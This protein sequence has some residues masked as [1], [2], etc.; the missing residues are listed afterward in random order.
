MKESRGAADPRPV[1]ALLKRKLFDVRLFSD[2]KRTSQEPL[3]RGE[4]LYDFYNECGRNGY[5][6]FRSILNLWLSEIESDEHRMELIS[7]AK[8]G[9]DTAFKGVLCELLTHA[10][11]I[12]LGY[13]IAVHPDVQASKKRPD[14]GLVDESGDII[15][16]IEVTTINRADEEEGQSNREAAIYNAI[17]N[18]AL[19][20]GCLLG[21]SLIKAGLDSPPLRPLVTSIERWAGENEKKARTEEVVRRFN[22]GG[23]TFEIELFSGGSAQAGAPAI[24]VASMQGGR[25]A[26]AED[27]R[28]ALERKSRRYGNLNVPY[29]IVVAD[30]KNQILRENA[31]R[32]AIVEAVY[33]DDLVSVATGGEPRRVHD[34]NGFWFRGDGC[35]NKH[36]SAILLM[37]DAG[38]WKLREERWQPLLAVNL[39]ANFSIPDSIKELTRIDAEQA[40]WVRRE[41]KLVADVL[42]LPV[43]WPPTE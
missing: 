7:R 22:A 35:H 6:E 28:T 31:V 40:K 33:G 24:G 19:P 4:R 18:S 12:R 16:Y 41:G 8:N 36:V 10:L 23:W 30:A 20:A 3:Q 27:V 21:Y 9:G 29:V 2:G 37:P 43:P 14:F 32:D 25:I 15:C 39:S 42:S 5:D 1:N 26:P 34:N 13:R 11:L 17:N 38:I